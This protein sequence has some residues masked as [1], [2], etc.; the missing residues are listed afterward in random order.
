MGCKDRSRGWRDPQVC[1]K[2]SSGAAA[3]WARRQSDQAMACAGFTGRC[4]SGLAMRRMSWI[5]QRTRAAAAMFFRR[6]GERVSFVTNARRHRERQHRRS[7][8]AMPAVPW[9]GLVVVGAKVV[10]R[11][12]EAAFD[13]PAAAFDGNQRRQWRAGRAPDRGERPC[14]VAEAAADQ[15]PG[16][17]AA[18]GLPPYSPAERL[19]NSAQRHSSRQGPLV[20]APADRRCQCLRRAG[21]G[22]RLCRAAD[23][24][25]LASG[26]DL[27][28]AR[29]PGA[30][31]P[32]QHDVDPARPPL[33]RRRHRQRLMRRACLRPA[34]A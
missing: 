33:R 26:A 29:D 13:G 27:V 11:C 4:A 20:P 21:H 18:H 24:L 8:V 3:W 2:A 1:D 14:A 17:Q 6:G 15:Q 30:H 22:H 34:P 10:P 7:D 19:A 5:D 31:T 23:R 28:G 32:C 16:V 12:L 9:P 25:C